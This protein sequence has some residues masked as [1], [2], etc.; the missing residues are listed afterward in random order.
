MFVTTSRFT[1]QA[2]EVAVAYRTHRIVLIDGDELA[3]LMV[4]HEIGVRT[5][6]T[7]RVQRLDLE[8]YENG[9]AV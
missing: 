7:I 3:R 9:D 1:V 5:V 2:R 4:E 8:A 6:Q